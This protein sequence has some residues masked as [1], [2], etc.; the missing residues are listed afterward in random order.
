MAVSANHT[1]VKADVINGE[2]RHKFK[3]GRKEITLNNAVLFIKN[4]K[5]IELDSFAF[6]II[7]ERTGTDDNIE[8]LTLYKFVC[9]ACELICTKV[10]KNIRDA[11]L[12]LA[13]FFTYTN[14][15]KCSVI[16]ANSAVK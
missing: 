9:L 11:E 2:S 3:L 4:R 7:L 5:K 16:F 1:S 6:F 15:N 13:F 12:R 10:R 8:F 14:I